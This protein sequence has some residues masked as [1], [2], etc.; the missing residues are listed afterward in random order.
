MTRETGKGH[1]MRHHANAVAPPLARHGGP[2]PR[3]R[4]HGPLA[5]YTA[6]LASFTALLAIETGFQ[7][8]AFYASERSFLSVSGIRLVEPGLAVD[9][10]LSVALEIRNSGRDTASIID[11]NVTPFVSSGLP[12]SPP[13]GPVHSQLFGPIAAGGII[14]ARYGEQ[15][16]NGQ[17]VMTR[18]AVENIKNGSEKFYVFGNIK[19]RD[20]FSFGGR[21][22]KFCFVY[23]SRNP[24]GLGTFDDCGVAQYV[25][26]D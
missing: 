20:A 17:Y 25:E 12:A 3:R 18:Q 22:T 24:L 16:K 4:L 7:V 23:I 21:N 26:G 6:L 10:P 2:R 11:S 14:N 1:P 19:Y 5:I 15:P 9:T 8:W 13:Y